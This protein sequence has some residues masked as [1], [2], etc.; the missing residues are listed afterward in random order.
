MSCR[1]GRLWSSDVGNT[2]LT[3]NSVQWHRRCIKNSCTVD[4]LYVWCI[5]SQSYSVSYKKITM[6]PWRLQAA[7]KINPPPVLCCFVSPSYT[8]GC[9]TLQ[10]Y[11]HLPHLNVWHVVCIQTP[12]AFLQLCFDVYT[13][14]QINPGV[15][16][17]LCALDYSCLSALLKAFTVMY[18][19][20]YRG[21]RYNAVYSISVRTM[22]VLYKMSTWGNRCICCLN[23][24]PQPTG[25]H[26][27]KAQL[28]N[29][30]SHTYVCLTGAN[31][32]MHLKVPGKH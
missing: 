9:N 30:I 21:L 11:S 8:F 28:I 25:S 7:A 10:W 5:T 14:S 20:L 1:Q 23:R 22:G 4:G 19:F 17:F 24:T 6:M 26:C 3:R 27:A 31:P 12:S 13:L 29:S 2:S 18:I 32:Q 16:T 15:I